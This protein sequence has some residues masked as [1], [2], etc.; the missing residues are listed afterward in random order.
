MDAATRPNALDLMG[1]DWLCSGHQPL[2]RQKTKIASEAFDKLKRFAD[3]ALAG[4][5]L[6]RILV[7]TL[8]AVDVQNLEKEF[9]C[10]DLD[11]SGDLSLGELRALAQRVSL[12]DE[13]LQDIIATVDCDG[14]GKVSLSEFLEAMILES[15]AVSDRKIREA[16]NALDSSGNGS[17]TVSE[18]FEILREEAP[19]LTQ[20][21]VVSFLGRHDD[22]M[23]NELSFEE[24]AQILHDASV[25]GMSREEAKRCK[26]A[27]KHKRKLREG[28][29]ALSEQLQPVQR[30]VHEIFKT[31]QEFLG[32]DEPHVVTDAQKL[33][34][35]V[36][37]LL[38]KLTALSAPPPTCQSV[39]KEL[40]TEL[41]SQFK[42]WTSRLEHIQERWD[43]TW[44][45]RPQWKDEGHFGVARLRMQE[46]YKH[47]HRNFKI[48]FLELDGLRRSV[49][50]LAN[51]AAAE[52]DIM[53]HIEESAPIMRT[54][55]RGLASP[56]D[57]PKDI[58]NKFKEEENV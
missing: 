36:C 44:D 42:F 18:L 54:S 35:N 4:Q 47:V 21:E 49:D 34:R 29:A 10:L 48:V 32:K 46:L 12:D 19:T 17:I 51:M 20:D 16:F 41:L 52:S 7:R 38:K 25:A 15:R 58:S 40:T 9:R 6:A 53:E 30:E 26:M 45:E 39:P 14:D 23:N 13:S 37:T 33:Y 5:A 28:L 2:F 27:Q 8:S 43:H 1:D 11:G 22:D 55:P 50:S 24:F 31:L 57:S 56:S 3:G